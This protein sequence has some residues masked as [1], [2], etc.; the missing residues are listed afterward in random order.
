MD[1]LVINELLRKNWSRIASLGVSRLGLFGS[2]VRNEQSHDSDID[3]LVEFSPGEKNFDNFMGL[4]QFLEGVLG[5]TVDLVTDSSLS[6]HIGPHILQEVE[7]VSF[8][9]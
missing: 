5:R 6:P 7:Y 2:Y 3:L 1:K 9:V 4:I 8:R